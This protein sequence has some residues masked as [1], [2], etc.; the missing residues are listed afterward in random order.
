MFFIISLIN[1]Q[2]AAAWVSTIESALAEKK[3][4][5]TANILFFNTNSVL[6]G[7]LL[8]KEHDFVEIHC[9]CS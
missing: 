7:L 8:I 4:Y 3:L 2:V 9:S 6:D 1:Y 5:F